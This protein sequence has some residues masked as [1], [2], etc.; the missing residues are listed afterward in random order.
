MDMFSANQLCKQITNLY[1][2]IGVCGI[3]IKVT[4]DHSEKSWVVHL[5]KESHSLKHFLEF[6]E[7]DRCMDGQQCV[8]LGLEIAQLQKNIEGK[9][10]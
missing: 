9:Q 5:K 7:A 10:F 4:K 1:P 6:M 8:A 2:E 3:D